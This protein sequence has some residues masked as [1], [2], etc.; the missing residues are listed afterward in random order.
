MYVH[1]WN[2]NFGTM[3]KNSHKQKPINIVVDC[4]KEQRLIKDLQHLL[5]LCLGNNNVSDI[6]SAVRKPGVQSR[7]TIL[8]S[9]LLIASP[10]RNI[11]CV[12]LP[13]FPWGVRGSIP[14]LQLGKQAHWG[15]GFA[16]GHSESV[17]H[18]SSSGANTQ[19]S[20]RGENVG[21]SRLSKGLCNFLN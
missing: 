17:R 13:S 3:K 8:P 4:K 12:L 6:K 7:R 14:V 10:I 19:H 16:T 2:C 11:N 9:L 15:E 1:L 5:Q 20:T 21:R 18:S